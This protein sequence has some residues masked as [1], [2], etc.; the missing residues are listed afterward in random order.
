MHADVHKW[1]GAE[2]EG[3]SESQAGSVL[4]AQSLTQGSLSR[5]V[6]S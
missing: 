2:S 6:R 1:E 5:I 3:E 4:S